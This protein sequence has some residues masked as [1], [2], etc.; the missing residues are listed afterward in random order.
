MPTISIRF[1]AGRYHATPLGSHVNE[2][3]I[4]WPPSP[5]R[6]LRALIATGFNTQHWS[7]VPD[8]AKS[9]IEKLASQPPCY[10]LPRVS[11]AHTRHYMP[12]GV[13]DA[14]GREKTTLLFDTWA[15]IG[16]KA[17]LVFW[18]CELNDD[19]QKLFTQLVDCLSYLGRSESW[20]EAEV[21]SSEAEKPNA[22]PFETTRSLGPAWEQIH[23]VAPF[24]ALDYND[25]YQ[26]K[27]ESLLAD[28]P[29]PDSNLKPTSKQYKEIVKRREKVIEPYPANIVDCLTKDTAW[30]KDRKWSSPPGS[31]PVLYVRPAE[32]MEVSPPLSKRV[33]SERLVT[34]VLLAMTTRSGNKAALPPIT[35]TLPQ[36]ELLHRQLVGIAT[37]STNRNCRELTGCDDAGNPLRLPHQHAHVLPLD[38]DGDGYLD[39]V[40][41]HAAMGLSEVAQEA[42]RSVR[43]TF[44]KNSTNDLQL[45]V[46]GLG[47]VAQLLS[48]K[49]TASYVS[50]ATVWTSATPLVLPRFQKK[51]GKNSFERQIQAELMS[52]GLPEAVSIELLKAETISMRHFIKSR[53]HGTN[54]PQPP[55]NVGYAM[56]LTFKDSLPLSGLPLCLGYASH[57]GL[58]VFKAE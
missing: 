34:S 27:T 52:R 36:A 15:H 58:G 24:S 14:N 10:Q 4:E 56:R 23:V 37:K 11:L 41:I 8:T 9:L 40:L 18:Q 13:M 42:I 22:F 20:V 19:E 51:S 46:A 44:S 49:A 50:N 3:H 39:H 28:F 30:W 55:V 16:D 6:L 7:E 26:R 21:I 5:W 31:R 1:P 48:S 2:G 29:E 33:A 32:Q 35:R 12:I 53:K 17:V 47:D 38:L 25:W 57:F 54:P 43:R 45:A